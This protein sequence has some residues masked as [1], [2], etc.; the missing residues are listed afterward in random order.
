MENTIGIVPNEQIVKNSRNHTTAMF[1]NGN[2]PLVPSVQLN[3][4]SIKNQVFDFEVP[5]SL[6]ELLGGGLFFQSCRR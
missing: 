6:E 3:G 2:H 4:R 5:E 1:V